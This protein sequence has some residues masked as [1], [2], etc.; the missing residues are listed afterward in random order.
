M[1][2]AGDA[3]EQV[4]R[5]YFEGMEYALKL[6]G[7]GAK[8]LAAMLMAA[9]Q[10]NGSQQTQTK[11]WGKER[12]ANMLKS[13]Q[14]LKIFTIQ[15]K[16]LQQFGKET[17]RYGVVYTA[18]AE[19]KGSPDGP[20]DIIAKADDAPKIARIMERLQFAT[21]DQGTIESK[22][23]EQG[24]E[25]PGQGTSD[26]EVPDRDDTDKL[27]DQLLGDSDGKPDSGEPVVEAAQ[28]QT[29]NPTTARTD[30]DP[31]DSRSKTPSKSAG[32]TRTTNKPESVRTFL[33]ERSAQNRQS[34][35]KQPERDVLAVKPVRRQPAQHQQPQNYGKTKLN[36]DRSR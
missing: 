16:D 15:N 27:L 36:K 28:E 11:L 13:G 31:S 23:A 10:D 20:C 26:R 7:A 6:A 14:P 1:S 34:E 8:H 3:A 22:L 12:L 33:W 35:E 32:S 2:A 24:Q 25:T 17:K 4:V 19:K 5:F 29:E 30:G 9:F 21:V 18:L